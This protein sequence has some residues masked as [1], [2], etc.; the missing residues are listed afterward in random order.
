MSLCAALV[1]AEPPLWVTFHPWHTGDH[2]SLLLSTLLS[3]LITI[4]VDGKTC[5]T[6]V[7]VH[8]SWW[9][10]SDA[11]PL[12]MMCLVA[13]CNSFGKKCLFKSFAHVLNEFFWLLLRCRSTLYILGINCDPIARLKSIFHAFQKVV[14]F[15]PCWQCSLVCSIFNLLLFRLFVFSSIA[16]CDFCVWHIWIVTSEFWWFQV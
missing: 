5:L 12:C 7:L 2:F 11:A 13:I 15:L 10:A 6:V 16:A 9:T 4:L 3:W 8:N 14:F 1:C